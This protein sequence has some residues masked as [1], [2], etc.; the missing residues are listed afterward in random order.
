MN[1]S[2]S[3]LIVNNVYIR[4]TK[5]VH[6]IILGPTI[7]SY[8][9]FAGAPSAAAS[10]APYFCLS[11]EPGPFSTVSTWNGWFYWNRNLMTRQ[12]MDNH[13]QH[14]LACLVLLS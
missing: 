1:N 3:K 5:N 14:L 11:F 9:F 6:L 2:L 13:S 12:L 7:A 8:L 4:V 10:V